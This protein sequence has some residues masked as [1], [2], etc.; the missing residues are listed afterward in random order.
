MHKANIKTFI[1]SL[2]GLSQRMLEQTLSCHEG[3]DL[4]GTAGGGLSAI[5]MIEEIQPELIVINSNFPDKETLFLLHVQ[6]S[7]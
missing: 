6:A 4:V 7:A 2:P 5:K 1:V 3:F